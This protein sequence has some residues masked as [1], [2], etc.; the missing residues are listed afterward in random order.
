MDWIH[1]ALKI[2]EWSGEGTLY[3]GPGEEVVFPLGLT[4]EPTETMG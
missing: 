4:E 1:N 2:P 3:I